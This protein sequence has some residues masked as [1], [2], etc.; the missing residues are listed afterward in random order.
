[1]LSTSFEVICV[2]EAPEA[3]TVLLRR[4]PDI[5]VAELLDMNAV[6]HHPPLF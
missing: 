6:S 1:M 5:V 2:E 3:A 4:N